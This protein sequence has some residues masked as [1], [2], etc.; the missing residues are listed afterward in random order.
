VRPLY[1]P[2]ETGTAD[3]TDITRDYFLLDHEDRDGVPGMTSIVGGKFT[4]YRMMGEEIT[5]HVCAK[6]GI[7]A[8]CRTAEVPLP[9][10]EDFQ[11]LRDYMDEFGLRS[12]SVV[13]ASNGSGRGPTRYSARMRRTPWS[14]TARASRERRCETP[15]TRRAA[16]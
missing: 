12:P 3:P 16:T 11:V 6:F 5:D 7:D 9:G 14:V 4:T 8:D 10:S 15:S 1:E 13:G 2:P